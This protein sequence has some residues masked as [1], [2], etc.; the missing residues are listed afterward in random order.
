MPGKRQPTDVIV[1]NGRKHLS[2]AEEAER[3]SAEV[4]LEGEPTLAPP[5]WLKKKHH[6]EFA[7]IAQV[8]ADS[9]LYAD[10]DGDTLAQ[11]LLCREA[12]LA[13]HKQAT[14]YIKE[15]MG[16]TAAEW[17]N[18][19]GAYFKQAQKCA[20]EMGL[21]ISSRCRLVLPEAARGKDEA[22]ADEFTAALEARQRAAMGQ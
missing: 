12:W 13:A 3:R 8:L 7:A 14:A 18:I 10:L 19:Q 15:G 5:K 20:T 22:V 2:M 11:Y 21:T 1:A 9:G 6:R 17:T 4:H 16:K